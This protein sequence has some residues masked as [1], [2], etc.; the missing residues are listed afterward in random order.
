MQV[1]KISQ[2]QVELDL[3][4]LACDM[5]L[6]EA[7]IQKLG[8]FACYVGT[9][10][11]AQEKTAHLAIDIL[12]EQRREA[13]KGLLR[14]QVKRQRL[15]VHTKSLVERKKNL[16]NR[17]LEGEDFKPLMEAFPCWCLRLMRFRVHFQ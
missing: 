13:L 1:M 7:K 3:S 6:I 5:R 15:I 9:N 8:N 4:K 16:Q 11:H 12:K 2:L 14:D 17:L 10:S